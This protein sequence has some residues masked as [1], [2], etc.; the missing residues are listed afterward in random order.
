MGGS[1]V[2]RN[3]AALRAHSAKGTFSRYLLD[4]TVEPHWHLQNFPHTYPPPRAPMSVMVSLLDSPCHLPQSYWHP[5]PKYLT[6]AALPPQ[7]HPG[8]A[9][10]VFLRCITA[11]AS[12]PIHP[13]SAAQ[14]ENFPNRH[15]APA[16]GQHWQT[17][18]SLFL[19]GDYG[20]TPQTLKG[21]NW[22]VWSLVENPQDLLTSQGPST[23]GGVT[24]SIHYGPAVL[25]K[26]LLRTDP[27][28]CQHCP[29]SVS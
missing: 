16:S 18:L 6:P 3:L 9:S 2:L 10:L 28:T 21:S 1:D 27:V 20:T 7:G 4:S 11:P 23:S 12:P 5:P 25:C 8:F 26:L 15:Q 24:F 14:A 19:P 17:P 29:Q 22:L 13:F